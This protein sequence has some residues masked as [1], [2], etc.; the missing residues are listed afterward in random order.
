MRKFSS[1]LMLRAGTRLPEGASKKRITRDPLPQSASASL[2]LC[3][4]WWV[5]HSWPKPFVALP[6]HTGVVPPPDRMA[7][8]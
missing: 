2:H 1:R 6:T 5:K 8:T 4:L 3:S 7:D